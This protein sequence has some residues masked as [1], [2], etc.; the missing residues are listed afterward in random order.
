M[1]IPRMHGRPPRLPGSTVMMDWKDVADIEKERFLAMPDRPGQGDRNYI[2]PSSYQT[3]MG[4]FPSGRC[5]SSPASGPRR[6]KV[7]RVSVSLV[8]PCNEHQTLYAAW[9]TAP[10]S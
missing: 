4:R 3:A 9:K 2:P 1:R 8:R 6:A 5:P 10:A 7:G